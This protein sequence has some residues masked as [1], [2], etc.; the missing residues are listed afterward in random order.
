MACITDEPHRGAICDLR[1]L[2]Q[3]GLEALRQLV[4][5]ELPGPPIWRLT[6]MYPTEV[7]LGRATFSMPITP[8]L[9]DSIGVYWGG[10]YPLFADSPL[11]S[12]IWSTQPTGRVPSTAELNMNFVRPMD[13]STRNIVGRAETV[14]SGSQAG[15]SIIAITDQD[16]RMLA[17]GST[18]C[19]LSDFAV[20][21]NDKP[22]E[23]ELGPTEPPDPYLREAPGL[24]SCTLKEVGDLAPIEM[25]PQPLPRAAPTRSGNSPA[26][27]PW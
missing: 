1:M 7:G 22:E 23:P 27:A 16:G 5:R 17:F 10:I 20:S 18:R 4:H 6:G 21:P 8:W 11:A 15:L 24:D 13:N 9:A 26:T 2:Q 12:A 14:H 19:L 3:S 25:Q